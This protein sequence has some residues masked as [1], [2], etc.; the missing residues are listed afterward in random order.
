MGKSRKYMK[1]DEFF[2]SFK[3]IIKIESS[4][5]SLKC[6]RKNIWILMPLRI[7]FTPRNLN[8]I[9]KM[10]MSCYFS[11]IATTHKCRSNISELPFWLLRE[12][13]KEGFCDD[14]FENCISEILQTLIGSIV[15]ISNLI[16]YGSMYTSKGIEIEILRNNMK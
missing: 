15:S 12:L 11:E 10:E 7:E 16:E 3:S 4:D 6:I 5:N 9:R 13:M 1:N 2:G 14:Q 8:C